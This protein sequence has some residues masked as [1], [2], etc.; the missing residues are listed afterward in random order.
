VGGGSEAD[1]RV[2]GRAMDKQE[3]EN[4][5][6]RYCLDADLCMYSLICS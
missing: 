2:M 3:R 5:H 6:M 4:I 1:G